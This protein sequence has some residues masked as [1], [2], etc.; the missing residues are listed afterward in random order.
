MAGETSRQ[1]NV[2][3]I[4]MMIE[5]EV[6]VRTHG[7]ET[8]LGAQQARLPARSLS[9]QSGQILRSRLLDRVKICQAGRR[10]AGIGM[11]EILAPQMF[12]EL[13]P[14]PAIFGKP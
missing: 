10:N 8:C 9:E 13:Y 7:V 11:A 12:R 3:A 5:D 4:G 1:Q 14:L 6:L 2:V